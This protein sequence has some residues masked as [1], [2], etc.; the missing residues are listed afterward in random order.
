MSVQ[1]MQVQETQTATAE[2]QPQPPQGETPKE[3]QPGQQASDE[4]KGTEDEAAKA[5]ADTQEAKDRDEKGRFKG[6]QPRIDELTK[7]RREAEREAQYWKAVAARHGGSEEAGKPATKPTPD[8][9]ED[10]GAYVEAL[11]DWKA[12]QAIASR[13]QERAQAQQQEAQQSS[14]SQRQAAARQALPDY[15]AVLAASDAPIAPHVRESLLDSDAGPALAYHFAKNPDVLERL[16]GMSAMQAAREVGRIEASLA[17]ASAKEA[18]TV[19]TTATPKP[20]TTTASQGR[21]TTPTLAQMS[22][23]EYRKQRA[24]QGARWAR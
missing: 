5:T 6:V 17:P 3:P 14:W 23:E 13:M 16:N 11:T 7:A 8:K 18:A 21:A 1:E 15:D 10:Y 22:H 24:A 12:D 19:R 9:F 4:A 20:A 2:A